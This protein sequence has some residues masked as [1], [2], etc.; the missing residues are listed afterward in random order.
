MRGACVF[1]FIPNEGGVVVAGVVVEV[2]VGNPVSESWSSE[3][4]P[5]IAKM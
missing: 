1:K 3:A 4:I 5:K 2:P